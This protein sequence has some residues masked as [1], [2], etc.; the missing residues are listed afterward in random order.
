MLWILK[1]AFTVL[2]LWILFRSI[3]LNAF[4]LAFHS[5]QFRFIPA[6]ILLHAMGQFLFGVRWQYI[7][8][9]LG[10]DIRFPLILKHSALYKL[11]NFLLPGITGDVVR[12]ISITR[13][14]PRK[15][16]LMSSVIIDKLALLFVV[17]T[18]VLVGFGGGGAL[19]EYP[20]IALA[21]LAVMATSLT[22]LLFFCYSHGLPYRAVSLLI[23]AFLK[24]YFPSLVH[25][26]PSLHMPFARFLGIFA[27]GLLQQCTFCA[28]SYYLAVSLG[29]RIPLLAWLSV[30]SI[31]SLA[32][33]IPLTIGGLGIREGAYAILLSLYGIS[34]A[35]AV[36]FSLFA[37]SVTSITAVLFWL[38]LVGLLDVCG[39]G[40]RTAQG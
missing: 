34:S 23:P 32:R 17:A 6:A 31:S 11:W 14:G 21:A 30:F 39:T 35:Q 27:L 8:K 19:T 13:E 24:K 20:A 4:L 9:S 3:D 5:L 29:I 22:L 25:N 33:V 1:L 2:I 36:F 15:L 38:T 40:Y 12:L 10:E 7:L 26:T 28:S 37:F 18:L 16:T